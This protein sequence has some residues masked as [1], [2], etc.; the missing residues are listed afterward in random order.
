MDFF[1]VDV[2]FPRFHSLLVDVDCLVRMDISSNEE[3][4][5]KLNSGIVFY[6]T[7]ESSHLSQCFEMMVFI[8]MFYI[9][10]EQW[11]I[12]KFLDLNKSK[13]SFSYQIIRLL[14]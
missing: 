8:I 2:P 4:F 11:D 1:P 9:T 10:M 14:H 13:S 12:P 3:R 6:I 7:W 5:P